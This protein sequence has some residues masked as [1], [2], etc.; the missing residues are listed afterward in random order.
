MLSAV[1]L[2]FQWPHAA[3]VRMLAVVLLPMVAIE[4]IQ[5]AAGD[6]VFA[7]LRLRPAFR[8]A[9]YV[10]CFY[11]LAVYGAYASKEFIYFQF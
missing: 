4:A 6:D 11:L 7:P 8:A 10:A 2:N 1:F 3:A 9:F 5:A